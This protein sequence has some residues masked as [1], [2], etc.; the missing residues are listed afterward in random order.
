MKSK[1]KSNKPKIFK[2]TTVPTA[3]GD[4]IIYGRSIDKDGQVILYELPKELS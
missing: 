4:W 2:P 3:N 1:H